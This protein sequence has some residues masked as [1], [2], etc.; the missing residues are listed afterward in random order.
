MSETDPYLE[1]VREALTDLANQFNGPG[2][3]QEAVDNF[4]VVF[5]VGDGEPWVEV[6]TGQSYGKSADLLAAGQI[7]LADREATERAAV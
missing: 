1:A 6:A 3:T 7:D 2:D 5:Q 4:V